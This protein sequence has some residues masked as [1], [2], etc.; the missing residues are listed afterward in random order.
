MSY[1][2][3]FVLLIILSYAFAY[4]NNMPTEH[5]VKTYWKNKASDQSE[6]HAVLL[7]H[8]NASIFFRGENCVNNKVKEEY[9]TWISRFYTYDELSEDEKNSF[10]GYFLKL[11]QEHNVTSGADTAI[12]ECT[13]CTKKNFSY[14]CTTFV[15]KQLVEKV[16]KQ[17]NWK[18]LY[19]K[20]ICKKTVFTT[21]YLSFLFFGFLECKGDYN[22][23]SE[24]YVNKLEQECMERNQKIESL[25]DFFNEFK[26]I[27][28][29]FSKC[30]GDAI[31]EME[32]YPTF[33]TF[34]YSKH[35]SRDLEIVVDCCEKPIVKFIYFMKFA[36]SDKFRKMC[37]DDLTLV[38]EENKN[39]VAFFENKG[40][41]MKSW[42]TEGAREVF[43]GSTNEKWKDWVAYPLLKAWL[44]SLNDDSGEVSGLKEFLDGQRVR[45]ERYSMRYWRMDSRKWNEL[46]REWWE[47]KHPI[48]KYLSRMKYE[49]LSSHEKKELEIYYLKWW[50]ENEGKVPDYYDY[51]KVKNLSSEDKFRL[52]RALYLESYPYK[53]DYEGENY[54]SKIPKTDLREISQKLK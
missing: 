9:H 44:L 39:Q 41:L 24:K 7:D 29:E 27:Y 4:G 6:R 30:H 12:D 13:V 31:K 23:D 3:G 36:K 14:E 45:S 11:L 19:M 43:E 51:E 40:A 38:N 35:A 28:Q 52:L 46:D 26:N 16:K 20:A 18:D 54:M 1:R 37:D 49:K 33:P 25:G 48:M 17:L 10:F 32:Y 5:I 53:L 15:D 22:F 21:I 50:K 2:V 8:N 42:V 34:Y 47:K